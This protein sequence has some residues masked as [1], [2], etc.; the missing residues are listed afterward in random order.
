[1]TCEHSYGWVSGGQ[2]DTVWKLDQCSKCKDVRN[3]KYKE[4]RKEAFK[5]PPSVWDKKDLRITR[6]SVLKTAGDLVSQTAPF[7]LDLAIAVTLAT[8]EKLENWVYREAI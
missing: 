6:M 1:M 5:E 3:V 7:D 8:A 2:G 4:V